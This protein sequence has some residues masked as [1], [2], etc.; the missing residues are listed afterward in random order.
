MNLLIFG[1]NLYD[2]SIYKKQILDRKEQEPNYS[3]YYLDNI[4]YEKLS[5]EI[6]SFD[7]FQEEKNVVIRK[8]DSKKNSEDINKL[9]QLISSY[10]NPKTNIIVDIDGNPNK[11]FEKTYIFKQFKIKKFDNPINPNEE[12]SW[13]QKLANK[14]NITLDYAAAKYMSEINDFDSLNLSNEIFKISLLTEKN[15]SVGLNE[16]KK[17]STSNSHQYKIFNLVDDLIM[18]NEYRLYYQIK[19]FVSSGTGFPYLVSM[20]TRQLRILATIKSKLSAG[21]T[22]NKINQNLKLPS[23]V[24]NKSVEMSKQ[25]SIERIKNLSSILL[26]EDLRFKTESIS[27]ENIIYSLTSKFTEK[28]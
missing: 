18:Q 3:V 8:T 17:Y 11:S 12:I 23:F 21:E 24:L 22:I 9:D 1:K 16:I 25:I 5:N 7:M 14:H 19:N 10:D 6:G 2:K 4:D 26:E 28:N 15:G 27:D 20:I 13:I